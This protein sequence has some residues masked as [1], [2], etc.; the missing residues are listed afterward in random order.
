MTDEALAVNAQLATQGKANSLSD[1][2]QDFA[3]DILSSYQ[4]LMQIADLKKQAQAA[5]QPGS[6]P[7]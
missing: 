1:R 6:P 5:R 7:M 2:Q 4:L 3:E